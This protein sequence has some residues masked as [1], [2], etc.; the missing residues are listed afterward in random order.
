MN[1]WIIFI[2]FRNS[3]AYKTLFDNMLTI[4]FNRKIVLTK[5]D[6]VI[7][8]PVPISSPSRP[9]SSPTSPT[10][11]LAS[12]IQRWNHQLKCTPKTL[13]SIPLWSTFQLIQKFE[14]DQ[15]FIKQIML[16]VLTIIV[17]Y[18]TFLQNIDWMRCQF[19]PVFEGRYI[20]S[21]SS[22]GLGKSLGLGTEKSC[23]LGYSGEYFGFWTFI[24]CHSS[25]SLKFLVVFINANVDPI[26]VFCH[27]LAFSAS[28]MFLDNFTCGG[29]V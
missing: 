26:G 13:W 19:K 2:N 22:I 29:G 4:P 8:L 5:S 25:G 1:I 28:E 11:S 18:L 3:V 14:H 24:Q 6:K 15:S 17:D 23:D 27:Q 20:S 9:I 12:A 10:S 16:R 7:A 21:N